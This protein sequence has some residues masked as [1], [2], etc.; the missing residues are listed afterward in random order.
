MI[1]AGED[2]ANRARRPLSI[3]AASYTGTFS[4]RA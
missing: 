2:A 1:W 3:E 4:Q